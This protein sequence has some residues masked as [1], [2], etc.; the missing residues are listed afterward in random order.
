MTDLIA[1]FPLNLVLFPGASLP[2][3]IFEPRY[4]L[5]INR[6]IDLE[7]PFGVVLI[8]E[9]LAEGGPVAEPQEVGTTAVLQNVL[10]FPDGRMILAAVGEQRFRITQIVQREPYMI[11]N[12]EYLDDDLT[13]EA[14]VLARR[15]RE[16]YTRHH[17][18]LG[19]ATGIS[20]PIV[21]LPDDPVALSYTLSAQFHIID[22]SK[23]QLLEADVEDRLLAL[24]DALERE[25]RFLPPPSQQTNP[26][27]DGP[28]TLN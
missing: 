17:E 12:V 26:T 20:Q 21:E 8:E 28:W 2:L 24:V 18:A 6:C 14:E 23:Q 15:A 13:P 9:G 3:H 5:M 16:L 4:R 10:K 7:Q 1:L 22:D 25:L 27:Y 19:Q 11:A